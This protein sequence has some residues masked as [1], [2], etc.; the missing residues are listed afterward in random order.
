MQVGHIRVFAALA[1]VASTTALIHLVTFDPLSWGA[2][3]MVSGFCFAGLYVVAESWL[4]GRATN[5]TRGSLLSI[6]FIIQTGGAAAGQTLLNF[7]SPEGILL[8]VI[9]SILI[10]LSLVPILA[11]PRP[12]RC[13]NGSPSSPYSDF[14]TAKIR[15]WCGASKL[16]RFFSK[17]IRGP[18][19]EKMSNAM[20]EF[21]MRIGRE[22]VFSLRLDEFVAGAGTV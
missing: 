20:V 18:K 8:F 19:L 12:L 5:E 4:N 14:G 21:I 10:S 3:R 17:G 11:H 7:S 1:S 2:M 22:R 9:I 15:P 6:Y 13:R 16:R